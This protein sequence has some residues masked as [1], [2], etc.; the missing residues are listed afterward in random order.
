MDEQKGVVVAFDREGR[1]AVAEDLDL[2]GASSRPR[3][4]HSR[5]RRSAAAARGRARV[6]ASVRPERS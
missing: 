6:W 2:A 3:T 4:W 5:F 1:V